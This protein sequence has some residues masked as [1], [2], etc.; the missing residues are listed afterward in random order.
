M[1]LKDQ[2]ILGNEESLKKFLLMVPDEQLR[3]KLEKAMLNYEDSARRWRVFE[4]LV[5][6]TNKKQ[7]ISNLFCTP[8]LLLDLKFEFLA[9]ELTFKRRNNA[10]IDV[11]STGY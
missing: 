7:V 5:G 4:E 3:N 1:M 2:D 9:S 6:S 8:I 11:S 10:A